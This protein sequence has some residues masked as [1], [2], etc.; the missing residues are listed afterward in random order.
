[1]KHPPPHSFSRSPVE[2]VFCHCI[3]GSDTESLSLTIPPP[4]PGWPCIREGISDMIAG[5]GEISRITGCMLRYTDLIPV[6]EGVSLPGTGEIV[7]L[8]S[9]RF[10]CSIDRSQNE[11]VLVRTKIP[12]TTGSVCS[13]QNR[14]GSRGW[15]LVFTMK[16]DGPAGFG[17]TDRVLDWFDDARAGIHELFDL[18]VPAEI[19]QALR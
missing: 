6:A 3:C 13:L 18:V 9:G 2:E 1:M 17:S 5:A 10:E 12:D 4:Y 11:I 7:H 19:V 16:T 14:P 8:L 15:T